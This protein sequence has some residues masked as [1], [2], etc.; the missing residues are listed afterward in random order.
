MTMKQLIIYLTGLGIGFAIIGM[1]GLPVLL[2]FMFA[3]WYWTLRRGLLTVRAFVYLGML[4]QGMSPMQANDHVFRIWYFD[5]AS[6]APAV[7]SFLREYFG[8]RQLPMI[9]EARRQGFVG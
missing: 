8:G 9:A 1:A 5:A 6:Y 3:L 4:T 7:K 2:V